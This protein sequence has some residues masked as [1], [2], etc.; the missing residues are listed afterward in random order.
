MRSLPENRSGTPQHPGLSPDC[1]RAPSPTSPVP[2]MRVAAG[3]RP[4]RREIV[5]GTCQDGNNCSATSSASGPSPR[6]V[7]LPRTAVRQGLPSCA[8]K[9]GDHLRKASA[10]TASETASRAT[11]PPG[12]PSHACHRM[13]RL[14]PSVIAASAPCTTSVT[15][16]SSAPH[17][18]FVAPRTRRG[19]AASRPHPDTEPQVPQATPWAPASPPAPTDHSRDFQV[20]GP[21]PRGQARPLTENGR[22]TLPD[23]ARWRCRPPDWVS[24]TMMGER[25]RT[26]VSK[27][28]RPVLASP[29]SRRT[30]ARSRWAQLPA[31]ASSRTSALVASRRSR[32]LSG[33]GQEELLHL[34]RVDAVEPVAVT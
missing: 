24:N 31:M 32:G 29:A 13:T 33:E 18:R 6:S 3:L 28:G 9:E 4:Q 15:C 23:T 16:A 11:S 14:H 10:A 8:A 21:V 7:S 30:G 26:V 20:R 5:Q 22:T 17:P 34:L 2:T 19:A 1:A 27:R 12:E 25:Q